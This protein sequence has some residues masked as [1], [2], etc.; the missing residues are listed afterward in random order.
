V[1]VR[2]MKRP[3]DFDEW[4]AVLEAEFSAFKAIVQYIVDGDTFR[5]LIS[6]GFNDYV[7][8]TIRILGIDT[9]ETNRPES[10]EAGLRAKARLTELIPPGEPVLIRTKPDPD[11]FGRYLGAVRTEAEFDI[12]AVMLREGF[13]VPYVR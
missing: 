11:S 1:I 2:G 13:A 12:G 8:R 10:K 4:P 3:A 5:A 6:N 9:P 7:F